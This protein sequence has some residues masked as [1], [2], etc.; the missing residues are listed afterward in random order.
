MDGMLSPPPF[1]HFFPFPFPMPFS[2]ASLRRLLLRL[3]YE[4]LRQLC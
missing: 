3:S 1:T 2:F 4:Q